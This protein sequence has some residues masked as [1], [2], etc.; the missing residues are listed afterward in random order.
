MKVPSGIVPYSALI[1]GVVQNQRKFIGLAQGELARQLGFSQSAYSRI[2]SGDTVMSVTQLRQIASLI[3]TSAQNILNQADAIAFQLHSQGVQV[4]HE[5]KGN[6]AAI[7]V[8][9]GLLGAALLAAS[10]TSE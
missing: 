1:G 8:G 5:K 3:G 2:E 6:S 7:L 9:L 4:T 10:A